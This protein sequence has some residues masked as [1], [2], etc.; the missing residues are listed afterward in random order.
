MINLQRMEP[1]LSST[2]YQFF[3]IIDMF[4]ETHNCKRYRFALSRGSTLGLKTGQHI[5]IRYVQFHQ[6]ILG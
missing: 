1:S 3:K 4:S 5:V 2:E 6:L